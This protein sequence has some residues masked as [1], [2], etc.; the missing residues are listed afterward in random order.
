LSEKPLL[1]Y[2]DH[3]FATE[4]FCF[5]VPTSEPVGLSPH[6]ERRCTV[7]SDLCLKMAILEQEFIG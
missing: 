2:S 4:F 5:F 6:R 3:K 1:T 7:A